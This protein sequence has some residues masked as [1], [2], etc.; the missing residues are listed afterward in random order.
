MRRA[1]PIATPRPWATPSFLLPVLLIPALTLVAMLFWQGDNRAIFRVVQLCFA[2]AVL[3]QAL[4]V[5]ARFF[6][7]GWFEFFAYLFHFVAIGA[8]SLTVSFR[9]E[10]YPQDMMYDQM[11]LLSMAGQLMVGTLCLGSRPLDVK[12]RLDPRAVMVC[13][14]ILCTAALIK[15]GF[16]IRYVGL[17]GG[18]STIYTEGDALRDNS[19]VII[20]VLAAGAPL[21]GL[22]ALTQPG[23][24]RWCRVLGGLSIVL[25]FAIGVRSRPLFIIISALTIG[26]RGFRITGTRKL[27]V[28]TGGLAAMIALIA[29]GYVRENNHSSADEY[30]WLVLE[31]LFGVFEA[32]VFGTQTPD[33]GR[34]VISQ[35][36]PLLQPTPLTNID[37][38]AKLLT[39]IYA[40]QG[41]IWGFG[42][43]SAALT[44][45]AILFGPMLSSVLYPLIVLGIVTAIR[46]AISSRRPWWYLYGACVLP[47]GFYIWRAELWQVLIPVI[48]ALPY[49]VILL[50][51]DAFARLGRGRG[52]G[53]RRSAVLRPGLP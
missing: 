11:A 10:Q 9:W 32:G 8:A 53:A 45:T 28:V 31:S 22:V 33:A 46:A 3:V 23:L 36:V 49:I 35:I 14:A 16:Y 48:K 12:A 43:S 27:L 21:I 19:P 20:R 25:E 29:I 34:L 50:G 44:E 42:Y 2:W 1:T 30:L 39:A 37:T 26:Q 7:R 4:F 5:V 51:A 13:A 17:S 52:R 40:Q 6:E 47:I 15:F 24:P 38:I 18:H 41:Y